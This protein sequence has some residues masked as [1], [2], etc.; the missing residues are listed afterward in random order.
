MIRSGTNGIK[1]W[2]RG[3]G[4][5]AKKVFHSVVEHTKVTGLDP[6]KTLMRAWW[7]YLAIYERHAGRKPGSAR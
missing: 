7:F 1:I 6:T 5:E 3:R 2:S 4:L